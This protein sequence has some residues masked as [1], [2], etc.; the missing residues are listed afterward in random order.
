MGLDAAEFDSLKLS[1]GSNLV[2]LDF[3]ENELSTILTSDAYTSFEKFSELPYK[4]KSV[5]R[6]RIS[7]SGNPVVMFG[8]PTII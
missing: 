3:Y 1:Y 4:S 7:F 5:N 2:S 8:Q 6:A